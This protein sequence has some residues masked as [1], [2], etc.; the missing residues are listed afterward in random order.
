MLEINQ[1]NAEQLEL[2]SEFVDYNLNRINPKA[3]CDIT[4][5]N[6][7]SSDTDIASTDDHDGTISVFV[8]KPTD[9]SVG[10]FAGYCYFKL[11]KTLKEVCLSCQ[12]SMTADATEMYN[13]SDI[14]INLKQYENC[15]ERKCLKRPSDEFFKL[16]R[17]HIAIF[18]KKF[19]AKPH[20]N[21]IETA[22]VTEIINITHH[23]YLGWFAVE[24]SC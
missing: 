16:C 18:T 11:M 7:N 17:L 2:T 21:S 22:K 3:S 20:L 1:I 19:I 24:L 13:M 4:F 12:N 9:A 10:Y 5:Q 8:L 15:D 23:H 14:V 6:S